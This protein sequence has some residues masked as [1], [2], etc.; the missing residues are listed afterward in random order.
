MESE[1]YNQAMFVY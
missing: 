1:A